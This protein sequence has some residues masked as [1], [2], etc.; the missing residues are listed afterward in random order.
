MN[1]ELDNQD[2]ALTKID[3]DVNN[4]LDELDNVNIK[5]KKMLD[6]VMK[7]D[8]FMVNCILVCLVLSLVGFISSF[9][10]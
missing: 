5:M 7:G 1:D 9:F 8:K 3:K 6:D 10:F 2:I 4:A